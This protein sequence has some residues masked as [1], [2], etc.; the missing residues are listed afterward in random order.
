MFDEIWLNFRMRSGAKV[1]T[2]VDLV[3]SFHLQKLA[4]I[5]PRRSL[6]KFAKNYP[7]VRLNIRKNIIGRLSVFRP[8]CF[9][10]IVHRFSYAARN[11][12]REHA[13]GLFL[14]LEL[15]GIGR[16]LALVAEVLVVPR[17]REGGV[18]DAQ[19]PAR[20]PD[21]VLLW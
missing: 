16:H 11:G 17:G 20:R 6:S 7:K 15:S 13:E 21:A 2:L 18:L 8:A 4:L 3:E 1:I 5:Q 14:D 12:R 19:L 10:H 9:V